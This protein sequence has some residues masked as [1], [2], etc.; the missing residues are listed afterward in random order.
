MD[1]DNDS[2][3]KGWGS[4]YKVEVF[5]ERHSGKIVEETTREMTYQD[6][7]FQY[8]YLNYIDK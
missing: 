7:I 4:L 8:H 3:T 5:R 6:E 1:D 2:E